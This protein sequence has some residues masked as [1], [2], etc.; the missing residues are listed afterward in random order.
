MLGIEVKRDRPKRKLYSSQQEYIEQV[1]SR[2]GMEQSKPVTTPMERLSSKST[3]ESSEPAPQG[4]PYRHAIGSLI[5]LVTGSRPDI[6]FAVSRLSKYLESP[7]Q[8]HWIAVKR[9]LRYPAGTRKH[10]ICYDGTRGIEVKG[11]SDSDY[12]GCIETR[13]STSGY[14]FLIAG[15]A[16]SWKS[17]KQTNTATST[18][19]AEY[20][21]CCTAT[22]EADWLSR[23]LADIRGLDMPEPISI[24]IHNA[25][26]IYL[27]GNPANNERSK[28][29]DVQYH[30]VREC[31]DSNKINLRHCNTDDQLADSLT[32]PLERI[33]HSKFTK[34]QGLMTCDSHS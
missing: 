18:C 4:T 2:F 22:K 17:K 20:M 23:L 34:L 30:F 27:A 16:V 32:K 24:G 33:K 10:A 14:I 5:Y 6:A 29:I 7:L 9:V 3:S 26:T 15:G 28:H 13:K 12:A 8:S 31:V 25:G 19:E 21:A 1:L 11:Y